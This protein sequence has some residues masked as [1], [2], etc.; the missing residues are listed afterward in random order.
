M[1][2]YEIGSTLTVQR[3]LNV[4]VRRPIDVVFGVKALDELQSAEND[5]CRELSLP[6]LFH[7]DG[8]DNDGTC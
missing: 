6:F 2:V 1:Y 3:G 4:C 8:R 5:G 7:K